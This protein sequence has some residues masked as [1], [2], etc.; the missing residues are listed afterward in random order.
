MPQPPVFRGTQATKRVVTATIAC[1]TVQ[2]SGCYAGQIPSMHTAA[3]TVRNDGSVDNRIEM[4]AGDTSTLATSTTR[5]LFVAASR[6]A[7]GYTR[8]KY[9]P[10]LHFSIST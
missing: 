2:N 1:R 5:R 6:R 10:G 7:P 3:I 8:N 9:I 4:V